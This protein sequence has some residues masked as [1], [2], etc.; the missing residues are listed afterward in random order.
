MNK[1]K[2]IFNTMLCLFALSVLYIIMVKTID[3]KPIG[4]FGSKVGFAG[5]N[6]FVHKQ[7]GLNMGWYRLSKY[8]G[9]ITFLII[10]YYGYL[11][12]M[13]LVERK[14][15]FKVDKR[16]LVLGFFYILVGIV[17]VFFEKVVINY[18]P[19]ILNGELEASFPS[20]HT[21]LGICV[22][23]SSLFISKYYVKDKRYLKYFNI[24]TFLIMILLV[25][26]RTLSGVHWITDI[27][28]GIIISVFLISVFYL[29][30]YTPKVSRNNKK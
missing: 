9:Y 1:R 29:F 11:G 17:Y 22:C 10:F 5:I 4:P 14:K 23:L 13:Q 16:L 15:L 26:S 8:L 18:R 3:V 28:G 2:M 30:I 20:S 19:V 24:C 6:S 25:I 21:M 12:L 27:I 7:V